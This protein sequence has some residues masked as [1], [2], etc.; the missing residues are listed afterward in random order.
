MI[1]SVLLTRMQVLHHPTKE[2]LLTGRPFRRLVITV[3]SAGLIDTH[4][5]DDII[6]TPEE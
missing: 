2:G 5:S 3:G 4:D 1:T 6:D